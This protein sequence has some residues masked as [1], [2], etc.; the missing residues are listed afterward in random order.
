MEFRKLKGA[1]RVRWL[2]VALLASL[3]AGFVDTAFADE[4]LSLGAMM[5][6]ARRHNPAIRAARERAR[7]ASLRPKTAGVLEDPTVSWEAW[8]APNSLDL[9][10]ADNNIFRIAQKL[11]YPGRL[12]GERE[13]AAY[14][15]ELEKWR[16]DTV[17]LDTVA[18][19][20]RAYFE[21]WRIHRNLEVYARDRDLAARFADLAEKKY[22][23]GEAPQADVIRAQVELSHLISRLETD[24]FTLEGARAELNALLGREPTDPLAIPED[25]PPPRFEGD[26]ARLVAIALERRPEIAAALVSIRREEARLRLAKLGLRPDFE[27]SASRFVNADADDGFGFMA[28]VSVPIAYRSKYDAAIAEA[29]ARHLAAEAERRRLESMIRRE[30]AQ[31]YAA[32]RGALV[33]HELFAATH[34]PHAE[35]SLRVTESAYQS[36]GV[37]FLTLV[38]SL[39]GIQ[40]VHLEH[41]AAAADFEKAMADLDRALGAI[42][43]TS[44]EATTPAHTHDGTATPAAERPKEE[45]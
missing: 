41:Y 31:A 40:A 43:T 1:V 3:V 39:R 28:V 6:D 45:R 23:V 9:S 26:L 12:G 35:Q 44:G 15:A 19:V 17:E 13:I 21:L 16:A 38:E 20:R 33:R 4:R 29:A 27:V 22:S 7:A 34:I 30:V 36:A 37:D 42:P 8:N 11:P 25:P 18:A 24:R 2:G 14:G 10:S 5:A 32:A